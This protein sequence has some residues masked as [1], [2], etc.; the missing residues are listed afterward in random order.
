[1]AALVNSELDV[2]V[3]W[4]V[5]GVLAVNGSTEELAVLATSGAG[6]G[7]GAALENS[8]LGVAVGC[9]TALVPC[10]LAGCV[11]GSTDELAAGSDGG[12]AL[13]VGVAWNAPQSSS[14]LAAAACG[15]TAAVGVSTAD[16]AGVMLAEVPARTE[17]AVTVM[18]EGN[19]CARAK[20]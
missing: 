1:M 10:A 5:P 2:G 11:N 16:V 7:A 3:A 12:A 8:K 13:G 9:S 20:T 4:L 14:S 17:A 19:S 18:G 15:F 6:S